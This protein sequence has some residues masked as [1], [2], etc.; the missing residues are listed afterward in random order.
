M[1]KPLPVHTDKLGR[2]LKIGDC[3]AYANGSRS[4]RLGLIEKIHPIMIGIKTK[5]SISNQYPKE[6]VKLD[7]PEVTLYILKGGK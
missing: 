4:L 5:G 2:D 3:V 7:G 1:A 6:T